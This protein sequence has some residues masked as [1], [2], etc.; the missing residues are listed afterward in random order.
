[1]ILLRDRG[2]PTRPNAGDL[3]D[4]LARLRPDVVRNSFRFGEK[5][6]GGT[7]LELDRL[8]SVRVDSLEAGYRT[9]IS[10]CVDKPGVDESTVEFQNLTALGA[11][12]VPAIAQRHQAFA[13]TIGVGERNTRGFEHHRTQI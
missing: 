4:D 1:M 13:L 12:V 6:S 7:G 11:A 3:N 10:S 5:G 9:T 2:G 8:P